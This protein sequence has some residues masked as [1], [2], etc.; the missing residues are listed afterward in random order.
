MKMVLYTNEHNTKLKQSVKVKGEFTGK[1]MVH[2]NQRASM[3]TGNILL[4]AQ[5]VVGQLR[6]RGKF[7]G[8]LQSV[9][10]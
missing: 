1:I 5:L 10:E 7:A 8:S 6:I 4:T 3:Q 9:Q 2:I